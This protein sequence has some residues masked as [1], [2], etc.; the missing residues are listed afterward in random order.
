MVVDC[1]WSRFKP[2]EMS[3]KW[4]LSL[5]A[6]CPPRCINKLA[7]PC[8]QSWG[9]SNSKQR[10]LPSLALP[11]GR[12]SF[13]KSGT[14]KLARRSGAWDQR[15]VSTFLFLFRLLNQSSR[16]SRCLVENLSVY[17]FIRLISWWDDISCSWTKDS[18]RTRFNFTRDLSLNFRPHF[19]GF[20]F[21]SLSVK[22]LCSSNLSRG[23][24]MR[25]VDLALSVP[26]TD[27]QKKGRGIP[28]VLLLFEMESATP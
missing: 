22:L 10:F 26:R 13:A 2:C 7:C 9:S 8:S 12:V 16:L 20:D 24:V 15:Q 23:P 11:E 14:S 18:S 21:L 6:C 3:R 5:F 28:K 17:L 25:D 1:T 27:F 19:S 4:S